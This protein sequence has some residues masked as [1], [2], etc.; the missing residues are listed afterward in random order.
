MIMSLEEILKPVRFVDEQISRSFTSAIVQWETKGHSRYSIACSLTVGYY[1]AGMAANFNSILLGSF[2]GWDLSSNLTKQPYG[3]KEDTS[4]NVRA[5]NPVNTFFKMVDRTIRLPLF[6]AGI[7][8]MSTG[9]YGV[10]SS[11]GNA[12]SGM[13]ESISKI[14]AGSSL[15][16]MASSL[17]VK[18]I[19]PKILEKQPIWKTAYEW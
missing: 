16:A 18:D 7:G 12:D 17:Y 11:I 19:N 3:T 10:I 15:L 13:T 5:I 14:E 9:I 4:S 6:L 2:G 8:Y 1:I